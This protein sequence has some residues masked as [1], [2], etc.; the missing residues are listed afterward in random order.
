MSMTNRERFLR[1]MH[2]EPV[3]HPPFFM[4]GVWEDTWELWYQQG[5]PKGTDL[6][7][8]CKVDPLKIAG[9]NIDTFLIPPIE[10]TVIEED[11]QMIIKTDCY[12]AKIR[13]FKKH[14]TM[15]EWLEY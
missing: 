2:F 5:Y 7:D 8:Y 11:D 4:D 15:P 12:G 9:V 1:T 10:P 13:T 3:D 14:T 6:A